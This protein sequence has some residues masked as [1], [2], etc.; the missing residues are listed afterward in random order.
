MLAVVPPLAADLMGGSPNEQLWVKQALNLVMD[1][2]KEWGGLDP[3][4][5]I[6]LP[7]FLL[8][9][10]AHLLGEQPNLLMALLN[11]NQNRINSVE[12]TDTLHNNFACTLVTSQTQVPAHA[13]CMMHQL[14]SCH[15]CVTIENCMHA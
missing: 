13:H 14:L 8:H 9:N 6:V 4:D 3:L 2:S 5:H 1:G 12:Q 11:K 10:N 7:S 15:V